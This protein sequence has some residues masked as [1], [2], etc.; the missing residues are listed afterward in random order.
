MR[1]PVGAR[2]PVRRAGTI[3][4]ITA[5]A[6]TL[7]MVA[8]SYVGTPAVIPR[9]TATSHHA[10]RQQNAADAAALPA[11]T[12]TTLPAWSSPTTRQNG[13]GFT[14]ETCTAEAPANRS[15]SPS[16]SH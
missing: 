8:A 2:R 12:S 4:A 3:S 15:I 16:S 11:V 9:V 1:S 7:M 10:A 5:V 14:V 6:I 13:A